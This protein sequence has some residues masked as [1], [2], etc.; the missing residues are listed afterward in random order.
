M[1]FLRRIESAV[2]GL[3]LGAVPVTSGFLA[4]WWI[5]VPL[6]PES[7][8]YQFALV[9]LGLGILVDVLFLRG[10]VR[11]AYLLK[12][13][14]WRAVYVFYSVGMLG[15]FMGVPVFNVALAFP[16]GV[17]VGRWLVHCGAD[18]ARVRRTARDTALFTTSVLGLVCLASASIALASPSTAADLKG[19]LGFPFRVTRPMI[20]GLIVG[21]GLLLLA[22][23][24]WLSV[25]SV[26]TSHGHF[27]QLSN[28]SLT[29]G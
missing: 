13:W 24:W 27:R 18:S 20:P 29:D 7:R 14:V 5:S 25:R 16:A 10:W 15:C 19:M 11:R 26:A 1:N 9:G 12:P 21:G 28:P 17:F 2:I 6:V 3:A 23:N 8:I 22:L 4:G